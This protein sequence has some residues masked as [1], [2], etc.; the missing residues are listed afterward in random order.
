MYN[1]CT[2][3]PCKI[4]RNQPVCFGKVTIHSKDS[5]VSPFN[6]TTLLRLGHEI[7]N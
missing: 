3:I 5:L 4:L 6:L 1:L 2:C 7:Q